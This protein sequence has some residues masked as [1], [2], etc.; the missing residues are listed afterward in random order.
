[1]DSPLVSI[2]TPTY[3]HEKYIL[4]CIR[5]VEGQTYANWEMLIVNDG[6][7]DRTREVIE[8]YIIQSNN[9]RILLF[10]QQNIGIFRLAE[11][12]NF[13]LSRAKGKYVA[14]LEGDDVWEQDKLER[15]VKALEADE[16]AVLAWGEVFTATYDL[17][18]ILGRHPMDDP[19]KTKY[20]PNDP[21]G[22]ILNLLYFDNC[23]S[24][25]TVFTRK[26]LLDKIGGFQQG[27]GLPLVDFTTW[28]ELCMYGTFVFDKY[29]QGK[30]RIYP[31]QTTKTYPVEIIKGRYLAAKSHYKRWEPKLKHNLN[32]D[33]NS[34]EMHFNKLILV[35]YARS[36]RYKLI[37]KDFPGARKDYLEAIFYP[38]FFHPVWR[39]RA[40]IGYLFSWIKMDVEWLARLLGK[41]AYK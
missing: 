12:Y 8:S 33:F 21:P 30:W 6:S 4:D 9:A 23:I 32:V 19:S 38:G 29:L 41:F 28:L 26:K 39:L 31:Y 13:A 11:T 10:N 2:I 14:V 24:A 27:F 34:L 17:S 16:N 20:Y 1:M 25:L 3:N 7:T 40:L 5:S 36:G 37:R 15:Q 22:S 18:L 35:G